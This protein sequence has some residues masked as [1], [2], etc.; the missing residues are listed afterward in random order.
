MG[1]AD[2]LLCAGLAML[3][4]WNW[5]VLRL[6]SFF[7]VLAGAATLYTNHLE[8]VDRAFF[9]IPFD[10]VTGAAAL[11]IWKKNREAPALLFGLATM[12]QVMCHFALFQSPH[13]PL[14][15]DVYIAALN[16]LFL[17]QCLITG[18]LGFARLHRDTL[19]RGRIA[20]FVSSARRGG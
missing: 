9:F 10:V 7:L 2:L 5:P 4:G 13:T 16:V 8:P 18:G 1:T 6:L 17:A 3:C 12:G 20:D 14:Q 19:G 11:T 15:K